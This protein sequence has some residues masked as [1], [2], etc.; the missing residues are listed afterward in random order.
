MGFWSRAFPKTMINSHQHTR[1][2]VRNPV[3]DTSG[4]NMVTKCY[5]VTK[6]TI[7]LCKEKPAFQRSLCELT[8][9]LEDTQQ[10]LFPTLKHSE[11][12]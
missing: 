7:Y 1:S 8:S 6:T 12:H 4:G 10:D 11:S 3:N 2:A 9:L 5:Q